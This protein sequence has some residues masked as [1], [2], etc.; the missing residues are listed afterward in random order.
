MKELKQN[1]YEGMYIL[2][3]TL[4]ED[5]REKAL[6]KVLSFIE[7]LGGTYEKTIEWGRK[8]MAYEIKGCREGYYYLLFFKLPTSSIDEI[9]HENHLNEDLLRFMHINIEEVP[10]EDEVKFKAIIEGGDR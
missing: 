10:K 4:S 5:A 6:K 3:P 8:K 9:I 2:R 1:L 7:N